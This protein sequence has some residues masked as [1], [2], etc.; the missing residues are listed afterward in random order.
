M[1]E[2]LGVQD[3]ERTLVF[4]DGI[5]LFNSCKSINLILDFSKL[6]SVYRNNT[7]LIRMHYYNCG[8]SDPSTPFT[9][10]KLYDFLSYN[11]FDVNILYCDDPFD[12][13]SDA[14][15]FRADV[16]RADFFPRMIA[17]MF[18]YVL[19]AKQVDRM[20]IFSSSSRFL[21]FVSM[22][23]KTGMKVTMIGRPEVDDVLRRKVDDYCLLEDLE[24]YVKRG[25][26][27][28]DDSGVRATIGRTRQ[29]A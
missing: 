11:G 10:R 12:S 7:N 16:L 25:E 3:Y 13:N 20:V 23:Q 28:Y 26:R 27:E 21:P 14:D 8:P 5:S 6:L 9:L 17:D 29:P 4:I 19:F 1:S 22:I 2:I 18:E 24:P 15:I